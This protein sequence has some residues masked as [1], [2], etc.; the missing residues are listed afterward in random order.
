M[1]LGDASVTPYRSGTTLVRRRLFFPVMTVPMLETASE[2][3]AYRRQ[4]HA[5]EQ[6]LV[7]SQPGDMEG[8][9]VWYDCGHDRRRLTPDAL[10]ELRRRLDRYSEAPVTAWPRYGAVTGLSSDELERVATQIA[11]IV[12]NPDNTFVTQDCAAGD[13]RF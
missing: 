13:T 7:W 5:D 12:R 11:E 3:L 6:P 2:R 4:C 1:R 10:T 9:A 8:Y